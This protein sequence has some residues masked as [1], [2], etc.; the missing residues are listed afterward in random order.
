[1]AI[2]L[3]IVSKFDDR[4]IKEA[5]GALGKFG[6]VAAGIAA[7]ATAA[8]AGVAI[9]SVQAFADFDSKLNQS[10]AIM[11]DVSDVLRNDMADAAREVAKTTT[12]SADQAA[13][14]FFFLASAGLDAEASIKAMPEVAKFAQA[15]MFDMALATDLLTDAQS[16]LGLTIRDDA[17]KNMENMVRVSDVLVRANTLANASV[18]QFSTALTT[19]AGAAL[20]ALGKDVEEGV[21][22]LAAFADQGIKGELAGTQ[23]SIVLRDL[24][25]KAIKNK[26]D[27]EALGLQVFDSNGEMRNLGDIVANLEQVLAGMSDETQKATLL[28]AGFSDKSL[29]SLTALLGTSEAIKTYEAEL[30]KAG[31]T[32][33]DISTKQLDTF[34]AQMEL[35]KSR[36]L[37]VAIEIGGQLAPKLLELLDRMSPII[38]KAAP[39]LL[40]LFDNIQKVFQDNY[41]R[42]APLVQNALPALQ[43]LFEDLKEPVGKVLE[44]LRVL[45]E[46]V[47]QAVITLV[48]N[49]SFLSALSSIGKSFGRIFTEV[50]KL[51]ES[52]VVKFLLDLTSNAIIAGINVL[53]GA[54]EFLANVVQRVVDVINAFNRTSIAP[55]SVP[56]YSSPSGFEVNR[57]SQSYIPGLADGGIVM[58]RPGGVFAN[59]AEA[60]QPEAVIPLDRLGKMGNTN[61]YNITVNAGMGSDGGRIGQLIVDEIKKFE[62][63]NGPVFAG[64]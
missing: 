45:G 60:G 24:S 17:I 16:A 20:R 9:K 36:L 57:G 28:Q 30:R 53:A 51:I 5:E 8:V 19:K 7:A 4:G 55:K 13:E 35:L 42:L 63:A 64:A 12:F 49:P 2:N 44:F 62:R 33:D 10:I 61:T 34:N 40:A 6:K 37:D 54:F 50:A 31:G 32:T 1:M 26:D 56:T 43:Q 48:T 18:E 47:L 58:P 11:G 21:A 27:F 15:G 39:V 29:A 41:D 22:V 25:T 14:S 52:P 38:E 3:P 59:I 46:T 23:L